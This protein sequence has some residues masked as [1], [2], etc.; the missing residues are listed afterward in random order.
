MQ[1][2]ITK[3]NEKVPWLQKLNYKQE[4]R[5]EIYTGLESLLSL[6]PCVSPVS[7]CKDFPE[8]KVCNS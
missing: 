1:M 7:I 5:R 8:L 6:G 3:I 2:K 4:Y